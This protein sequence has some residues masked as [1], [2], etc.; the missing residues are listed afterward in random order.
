MHG[1]EL[2]LKSGHKLG[3]RQ[4]LFLE[5]PCD[6]VGVGLAFRAAMQVEEARIGARQLQSFVAKT[7][8]PFAIP[9]KV[10]NGARSF[11]SCAMSNAGPLIVRTQILP[12]LDLNRPGAMEAA[13]AAVP[14]L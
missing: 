4:A 7:R 3:G 14:S 5:R 1:N 10:L 12:H 13:I 9:G 6:L 8:R 11:A 2:T